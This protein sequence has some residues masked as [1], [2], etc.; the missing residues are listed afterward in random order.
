MT[1]EAKITITA[2]NKTGAA[3]NTLRADMA[4]AQAGAAT[5]VSNLAT[6]AP[7]FAAALSASGMG[8]HSESDNPASY[9]CSTA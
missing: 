5:L 2:E 3:F 8:A 1:N 7:A 6:V 9:S 4:K